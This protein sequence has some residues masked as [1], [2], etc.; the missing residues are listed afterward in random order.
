MIAI[1]SESE[2]MDGNHNSPKEQTVDYKEY[3]YIIKERP[4]SGA[5]K[6]Q[7]MKSKDQSFMKLGTYLSVRDVEKL[8]EL[9]PH[10]F[11]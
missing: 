11:I 8:A 1:L 3:D 2:T 6:F 5:R 10:V 4:S 7:V 9:R